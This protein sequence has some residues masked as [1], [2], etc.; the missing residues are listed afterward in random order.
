MI[1]SLCWVPITVHANIIV[2][3]FQKSSCFGSPR[4]FR[5]FFTTP[6][7]FANHEKKNYMNPWCSKK[8]PSPTPTQCTRYAQRKISLPSQDP[9]PPS[10]NAARA[11]PCVALLRRI[12]SRY[13]GIRD[14]YAA[15]EPAHAGSKQTQDNRSITCSL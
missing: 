12:T 4:V 8:R 7:L 2:L 10:R 3:S 15:P 5:L 13:R 11:S 6:Q 1:Q 14:D 9:S